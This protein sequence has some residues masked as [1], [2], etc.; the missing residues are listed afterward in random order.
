[1]DERVDKISKLA[2]ELYALTAEHGA[3]GIEI[4]GRHAFVFITGMN[5]WKKHSE[6]IIGNCTKNINVPDC[7]MRLY[8][9][10]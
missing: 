6:N 2:D 9:E 8:G 4:D 5:R 7:R 3:I 1:M 10:E